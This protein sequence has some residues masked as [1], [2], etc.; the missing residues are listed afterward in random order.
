MI[1]KTIKKNLNLGD[2][3]LCFLESAVLKTYV[4][5]YSED[6]IMRILEIEDEAYHVLLHNLFFKYST[7]D[8]FKI[9]LLALTYGQID[10]YDLVK[11]EVKETALNYSEKLKD[12]FEKRELKNV[13]DSMIDE[14]LDLF[15]LDINN[16]FIK[17]T[18]KIDSFSLTL[19]EFNYCKLKLY[20]YEME[21]LNH[22]DEYISAN[23]KIENKLVDKFKVNNFYN[24][25]RRIFELDLIDR[26]IFI[27]GYD[28]FNY[29]LRKET[30]SKIISTNFKTKTITTKEEQLIIYF[31][32]INYYNKLEDKLLFIKK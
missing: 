12:Y 30:T 15:L 7:T 5:D 31:D 25:V 6:E 22:I 29:S 17:K 9:I 26:N 18:N 19:E 3:E 8:F 2:I 4:L 24:A 20:R 1:N 27:T 28:K 32:L 21:G 14:F 13:E 10:R 16:L 11:D 23:K